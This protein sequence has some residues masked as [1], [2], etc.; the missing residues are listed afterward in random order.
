M[1]NTTKE[2][3]EEM[4]IAYSEMITKVK[5]DM[6]EEEIEEEEVIETCLDMYEDYLELCENSTDKTEVMSKAIDALALIAF[7]A[8]LNSERNG[9][10]FIQTLFEVVEAIP[11]KEDKVKEQG[12]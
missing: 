9:W 8:M 3:I 6:G 7:P 4:T 12:A 11:K 2:L 10:D 5:E 1:D